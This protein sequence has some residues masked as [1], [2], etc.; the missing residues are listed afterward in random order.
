MA[1]NALRA[2]DVSWLLH[3]VKI[4]Q[5]VAL[6]AATK[7][8]TEK[9]LK[10]VSLEMSSDPKKIISLGETFFLFQIF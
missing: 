9:I 3:T 7:R 5:Y 2:D 8:K 6:V 4:P 1:H 10:S